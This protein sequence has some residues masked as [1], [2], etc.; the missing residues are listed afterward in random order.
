MVTETNGVLGLKVA[1][2]LVE[3]VELIV[4]EPDQ[5][6]LT[7]DGKEPGRM[8][9]VIH[10]APADVGKVIGKHGRTI[11]A[12]RCLMQVIGMGQG[13]TIALDV[14]QPGLRPV[15]DAS[16]LRPVLDAAR[17]PQGVGEG[18]GL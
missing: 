10:V 5:V 12:L 11:R 4:A 3:M 7:E 8:F 6:S 13:V 14:H 2:I 17:V 9:L 16:G 1:R 18:S 15:L